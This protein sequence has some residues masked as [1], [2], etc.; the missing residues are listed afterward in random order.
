MALLIFLTS[1]GLSLDVHFCQGNFKRA[2]IFGKAKTCEE[3]KDCLIKCGK[4]VKSCHSETACS[5]DTNHNGCCK[6]ES[7]EFD[8][9][10]DAFEIITGE[11]DKIQKQLL[12]DITYTSEPSLID[13]KKVFQSR[14]YRPP[15][16]E[17]DYT[18]LF[19]IFRL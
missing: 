9:D 12:A 8:L 15:P 18:V 3:V 13:R 2:N 7:F 19:Q 4:Q 14:L 1:S 11:S 5:E 17:K 6:N 16:L 10:L